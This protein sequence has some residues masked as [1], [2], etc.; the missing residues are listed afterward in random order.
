MLLEW[1]VFVLRDR[2]FEDA[3]SGDRHVGSSAECIESIGSVV[4]H[5]A[6]GRVFRSFMLLSR[7]TRDP[8]ICHGEPVTRELRHPVAT[9]LE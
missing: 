5:C 7:L 3:V 1:S 2:G 8:N 6:A 9:V 4:F